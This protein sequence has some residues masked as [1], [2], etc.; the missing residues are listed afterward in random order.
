[1]MNLNELYQDLI[2][3][4]CRRP[5]HFGELL[6][7]THHAL[8]INPICG[9]EFKVFLN[10]SN[11]TIDEIQF[12]GHG[13]AISVASASLMTDIICGKSMTDALQFINHFHHMVTEEATPEEKDHLGKLVVFATVKNY[14]MRVK[15]ATLAWH[16][17]KAAIEKSATPVTTEKA[18]D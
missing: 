7:A 11:Y 15:C 13:C 5:H 8:G 14:P 10:T 16:T 12:T 6:N 18:N 3:D 4:H 1:M 17:L 2:L 9:D